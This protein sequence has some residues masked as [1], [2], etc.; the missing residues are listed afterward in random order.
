MNCPLVT[1]S[2]IRDL[3]LLELQAQSFDRYLPDKTR[4]ILIINELPVDHPV[5]FEYFH[6]NIEK[7]YKRHNLEIYKDTDFDFDWTVDFRQKEVTGWNRQQVL[8]M[9]ISEKIN[10]ENY[11]VLDSQNFL[12]Q[13]W[14]PATAIVDNKSPYLPTKLTWSLPAYQNYLKILGGVDNLEEETM[15]ASTPAFLNSSLIKNLIEVKYGSREFAKWF[16]DFSELKSEFALYLAWVNINGGVN[17]YHYSAHAWCHPM[18]RDSPNFSNDFNYFIDKVSD[19]ELHKWASINHRSWVM[20]AENQYDKMLNR[21]KEFD[22]TPD[23][24]NLRKNYIIS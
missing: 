21:L 22:L 20:M 10:T 7:Y 19:F 6:S 13:P 12:V 9:L 23:M 14:D 1:V 3:S 24:Q 17:Q 8:K 11:C 4:I 2:C 15:T 18:L 16:Y 5:W